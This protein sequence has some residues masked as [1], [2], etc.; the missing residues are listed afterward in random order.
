MSNFQALPVHWKELTGNKYN[1]NLHP[2]MLNEDGYITQTRIKRVG[3]R[4]RRMF[5]VKY[6]RDYVVIYIYKTLLKPLELLGKE[7]V[8]QIIS[9]AWDNNH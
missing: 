7:R 6:D 1:R 9:E 3:D 8:L 5:N 4:D 2:A